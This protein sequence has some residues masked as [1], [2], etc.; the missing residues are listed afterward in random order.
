M[1]VKLC[2]QCAII[3]KFDSN[4]NQ[5]LIKV[6]EIETWKVGPTFVVKWL[7]SALFYYPTTLDEKNTNIKQWHQDRTKSFVG[8]H[9]CANTILP[10]W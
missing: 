6:V 3:S 4:R 7:D 8:E 1:F 2:C 10:S 9:W 5:C